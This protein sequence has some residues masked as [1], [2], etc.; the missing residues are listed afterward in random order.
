MAETPFRITDRRGLGQYAAANAF[1]EPV[2]Q[3]NDGQRRYVQD[4]NKDATALVTKYSREALV[5]M[6]RY[7]YQNASPVRSALNQMAEY[8]SCGVQQQFEGMDFEWGRVAEDWLYDHNRV[9]CVNGGNYTMDALRE[10]LL[11]C[12]LRDGDSFVLLTETVNGYPQFQHI[13]A[14]R[15]GSRGLNVVP[16]GPF[17]GY[18][19]RDGVVVND[20]GRPIGYQILGNL[21]IEDR[22]VSADSMVPVFLP[23]YPDQVRG[24]PP[25]VAAILDCQDVSESRRLE[26]VSQKVFSGQSLIVHNE[27][28]GPNNTAR[29]IIRAASSSSTT[30]TDGVPV[31]VGD[32]IPGEIRYFRAGSNSKV[33]AV[34]GDRPTQNQREFSHSILRQ[35]IAS[36]GWSIDIALDQTKAG[37]AQMR[38]VLELCNR[39]LNHLRERM[40]FPALRRL[41]GYR[42]AKAQILGLVPRSDEWYKWDYLSPAELTADKK[43]DA[44]VA[45]DQYKAGWITGRQACSRLGLWYDDVQARRETETLELVQTAQRISG[46]T[47]AP[48]ET[49][50]VLL[51]D[52]SI[53]STVT[54][55]AAAMNQTT[56][57]E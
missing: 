35:A 7:L 43:Y 19:V 57:T 31:A 6:G 34:T 44:Q 26:M 47:G 53:Y 9:C 8:G 2:V 29:E 36:I 33:E 20:F 24:I 42:I 39:R 32:V 23:E 55:S 48:F 30:S 38:V 4:F 28:G 54:N 46:K 22:Y 37:G 1:S 18:Q 11:L 10:M 27:E 16:A 12:Y 21:P 5:S 41:D 40:L 25:L 51:R 14:H 45:L 52:T 3:R 50:L 56:P 49:I 13:P 15:I 17:V